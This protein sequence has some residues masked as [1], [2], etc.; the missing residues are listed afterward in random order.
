MYFSYSGTLCEEIFH[1]VA[2]TNTNIDFFL[3]ERKIWMLGLTMPSPKNTQSWMNILFLKLVLITG[4]NLPN[5]P[6]N[7]II[8]KH[9][10][11]EMPKQLLEL[12]NN[13]LC[14]LTYTWFM[15]QINESIEV[16][17][18]RKNFAT[19]P[20]FTC[21]KVQDNFNARI[22]KEEEKR[23]GRTSNHTK[24]RRCV[25]CLSTGLIN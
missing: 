6:Y 17:S 13:F 8:C 11:K 3:F 2:V 7:F 4:N 12:S 1:A 23:R 9:H 18:N 15:I 25:S 19:L 16:K 20:S 10:K 21:L 24:Y 14:V 5:L 22:L